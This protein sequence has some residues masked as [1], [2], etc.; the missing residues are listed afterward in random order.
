MLSSPSSAYHMLLTL[1]QPHFILLTPL[2]AP[3]NSY[4]TLLTLPQPCP[5]LLTLPQPYHILLT[6]SLRYPMLGRGDW[7]P[8][9]CRGRAARQQFHC[10]VVRNRGQLH[11]FSS[12]CFD[13]E[14]TASRRCVLPAPATTGPLGAPFMMLSGDLRPISLVCSPKSMST[15]RVFIRLPRSW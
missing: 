8:H 9:S 3:P 13:L 7:P 12:D 15:Q 2:P 14:T 6:L 1:P 10:F 11:E 4:P 5:M